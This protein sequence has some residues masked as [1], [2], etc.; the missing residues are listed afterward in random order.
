M[1][2]NPTYEELE[3]RV[4]ELEKIE[5]ELKKTEA[6]LKDE[7]F[8]RRLLIEESR[9][10][11]VILDHDAKVYDANSRF[12][13][14]LGYKKEEVYPLH[15]W[16]WDALLDKEQILE[17]AKS[18]DAAGHH[19]ETRHRRKDGR[20]IDAELS[21]N[22]AFYRGQ[23]LILCICRDITERKKAEQALQKNEARLRQL[24]ESSH[25][26]VWEVDQNGVYIYAGPQCLELFGYFPEEII[27][28]TPFDLMDPEEAVRVGQIFEYYVSER[29]PFYRLENL[30]RH[31]DGRC[32]LL[33]TNGQPFIDENGQFQGYRGMD[34][35]ITEHKRAEEALRESESKYRLIAENMADVIAVYDMNLKAT[36]ISPSIR[37]LR[38]LSVEE[39]MAQPLD[40]AMTPESIKNVLAVF[41]EEMKLEASGTADPNRVRTIEVEDYRKDGSL[42]WLEVNL[43]FLRDQ[44]EKAIG[45]L[46]VS[47][48][49]SERK[50]S[51]S[52]TRS[53]AK[54]LQL[55]M[56]AASDG[57][58]I[59][60]LDGN[61]V[62]S[63]KSFREML[64]YSEEETSRLN[65]ADLDAYFNNEELLEQ[66]QIQ[67]QK[68]VVFETKH[69]RRDGAE[70]DVEIN[71]RPV[72][73][74]GKQYIYASSRNITERKRAEEALRLSEDKFRLAFQ[75][76]P[77][78]ININRLE[79]GLYIDI[80]QGFTK[81][82]GFT[83]E[84][85][86]GHTSKEIN[87]WYDLT[88][89]DRLVTGLRDQGFYENLEAQ[90]RKKDGSLGTALMS[91]RILKLG[92]TE[93]IISITRDISEYKRV[94]KE[95][96]ILKEQLQRAEKMEALGTLAG[97][98]AHDLNNVLG[99]IVGYSEMTLYDLEPTS[100]LR[101]ALKNIMEGSQKAAA[102]VQDLLTLARRGVADR[103]VVNL[104]SIVS[105][106]RFSPEFKGLS[107][108]HPALIVKLDLEPDLL[109]IAGS[110]V[111]LGKTL[112]NLISN[113]AEAMPKGGTV[114]IK[115]ANRYLD[116]PIQGHD[117]V[118][119]G[120]YVVL[121]VTDNGEGI[122]EKDIR[123][124]FEP[125]YTKKVMG[126]SGTGLGL[127]VVW[128]TVKDHFGYIDVT[129]EE[130]KG[131]TFTLYF[132]VTREEMAVIEKV[133]PTNE[134]SGKGES[135]LVIDD[136]KGQR[137][138]AEH[139]L[140]KLNYR[141]STVPSGEEAVN[142]LKENRV[143]LLVLD[144]IMDP[145]MDG[146]DT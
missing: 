23:K 102:I 24:I 142:Y 88:D 129:S 22:G 48:D 125:F 85:V 31:K 60:D 94:E 130:G 103:K 87:I 56:D 100:T 74:G 55:L 57:I 120:D 15:A 64:G 110:S 47:R 126:R 63:G 79:D 4:C 91:A 28:K 9:D 49:I 89:R 97:G 35:D 133:V 40:Q 80:N 107:S 36:Y 78:A 65:V 122:E 61:L 42:L 93:H 3:K 119:E 58:H 112:F 5:L 70:L 18:V 145:G 7:V 123:R 29:K 13:D 109:N 53:S 76:S 96:R 17:L 132:P 104:N 16:D 10:A 69:H 136:V 30:N 117:E 27:G 146:L 144:M 143:D 72:E 38:G 137:D 82:T 135:V 54:H 6:L 141:V 19:F 62:D 111:H 115:T 124:I 101:P 86:I 20:I 45:I 21:N 32:V 134:Y 139:M 127:A 41:E 75:T 50:R 81:L 73:I 37:R 1:Y 11:I 118:R 71:S 2:E 90:F 59:Y 34:R 52:Q 121:S 67:K 138:L 66:F 26:W 43:S 46:S 98:V 84:D 51:E 128:G 77:D 8:W 105:D 95:K 114:T 83:R 116:K 131:S 106:C 12:A 33:E 113:A 39:A 68:A 92:K 108:F 99:I 14:M 25:D 140:S 44:K